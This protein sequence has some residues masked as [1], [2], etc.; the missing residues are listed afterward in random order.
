MI[1]ARLSDPNL[2][3]C[4]PDVVWVEAFDWIRNHAAYADLGIHEL[5]GKLMFVNVM[6]Y[7]T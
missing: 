4:L 7:H 6:E 5:R 3:K 1:Y 2:S